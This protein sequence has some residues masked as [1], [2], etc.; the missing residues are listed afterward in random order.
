MNTPAGAPP[1]SAEPEERLDFAGR[2]ILLR[3]IRPQDEDAHH[4]FLESLQPEDVRLR[5]FGLL[6]DWNHETLLRYTHIDYAREMAFVAVEAAGAQRTLGVVRAIREPD[7]ARAE[8]AIVVRSELKGHGLGHALLDRLI[9][10]CRT[11]G[12][13]ELTGQVLAGNVRMLR[14]ARD[15][16]FDIS[17]PRDGMHTVTLHPQDGAP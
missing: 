3:P 8:F 9:R 14:L 10:Y 2:T 17:P 6:H 16:G 4:E 11:A 13:T 7:G 1:H 15:L 12:I 5:F